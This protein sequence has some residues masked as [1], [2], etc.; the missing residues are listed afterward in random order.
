MKERY[1][2]QFI[3]DDL[4]KKMVFLGGPRQS[5]KT[6][7]AKNILGDDFNATNTYLNWDNPKDKKIILKQEFNSQKKIICLDE[8]HKYPHWKN[9]VKGI[10]D[11]NKGRQTYLVTGSARL[12]LYKRGGDSLLGRYHYWRLHPYTLSELPKGI[13][14]ADGLKRLMTVGGFPEPFLDNNERE[15]RRWRKERINLVLREDIRDLELI[16][17]IQLLSLL[18]DLLRARVG[19]LII[20]SNLAEDLQVAPKTIQRWIDIL[21]KMYVIFIVRPFTKGI[22]RSLQKPCKIYFFDNG[23]VDGDDGARFENLVAASLLK[24]INFREDYEGHRYELCYLR[25]KEKREVDF[26][27]IK[28]GKIA[29]LI[30]A[31]NS[32][33]EVSKALSYFSERLKVKVSYQIVANIKNS[34]RSNG[35]E[36]LGPLDSLVQNKLIKLF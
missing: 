20:I 17:E 28:D 29:A 18:V 25:D 6:T 23:D 26:A 36:V 35:I 11:V 13:D 8:I 9:F 7:L 30:E 4:K 34:F 12:D 24:E 33:L 2:E 22:V 14:A 3:R 16:K 27:V 31:K 10:Y 15:A 21:E 1:L 32:D 5:G 19:G